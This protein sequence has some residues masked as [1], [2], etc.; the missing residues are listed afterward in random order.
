MIQDFKEKRLNPFPGLITTSQESPAA[1]VLSGS[2]FGSMI[3]NTVKNSN[4]FLIGPDTSFVAIDHTQSVNTVEV[5]EVTYKISL[6]YFLSFGVEITHDNAYQNLE[7]LIVYS[8]KVWRKS[9]G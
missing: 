2:R 6:A 5:G 3:G 8:I 7:E 1:F 9:H 4:S